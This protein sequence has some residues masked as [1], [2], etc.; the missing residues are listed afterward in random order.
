MHRHL[1]GLITLPL[2]ARSPFWTTSP[3]YALVG[4]IRYSLRIRIVTSPC[5]AGKKPEITT[6]RRTV[7]ARG[8]ERKL[9]REYQDIAA[10]P[11]NAKLKIK[12]P[13]K[14]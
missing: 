3:L 14:V 11:Q 8:V 10:R 13:V 2:T 9:E 1:P 7:D 4:L 12:R 5:T 6:L